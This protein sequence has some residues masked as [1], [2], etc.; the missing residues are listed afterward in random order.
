MMVLVV[1]LLTLLFGL[2]VLLIRDVGWFMR[3]GTGLFYLGLLAFGTLSGFRFQLLLSVLPTTTTNNHNHH[4]HHN[5]AYDSSTRFLLCVT[6]MFQNPADGFRADR[7]L[8]SSGSAKRR[9]ERRL[10][11]MLR[12]ERQ[13]VAMALAEKLHHSSRGQKLARAGGRARDEL[14]GC[15]PEDAPP[16]GT[17]SAARCGTSVRA[18]S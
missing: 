3:F 10:R 12:H 16:P 17:D 18:F 11:A 2:L 7:A 13:T 6:V 8:G 4:N 5:Q 14:H 15:A 1:L 9:R